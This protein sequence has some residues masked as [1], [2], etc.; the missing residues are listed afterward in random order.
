MEG[1]GQLEAPAAL[2]P[3]ERAP[4]GSQNRSGR[5]GEENNLLPLTGIELQF[6]D[7]PDRKQSLYRLS[8]SGFFKNTVEVLF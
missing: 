5:C 6:P 8:Y 7:H 4:G 2:P 1:S 3:G